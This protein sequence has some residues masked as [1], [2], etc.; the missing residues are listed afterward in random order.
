MLIYLQVIESEEDRQRFTHLYQTYRGLMFYAAN[1]ILHNNEDAEDAVHQ[2]F[3][4]ILENFDKITKV[5]CPKSRAYVVIITENKA[6]D[7]VRAKKH[8]SDGEF[9]E[10]IHGID[11]PLP[12]DGGLADAM[13]KLPARYRELLLLR[14]DMGY[15]TKEISAMLSMK[16]ETVQKV[17]WRAKDA[18]R[19]Q[20]N[21]AGETV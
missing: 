7:I 20:M 4:S 11:I 16:V 3:L 15:S 14:Y 12:G 19:E 8:F 1:Q 2:A 21:K 9:D 5:N 17:I 13:A 18:L 6:I 10:S